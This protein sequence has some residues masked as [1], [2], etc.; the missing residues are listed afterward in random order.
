MLERSWRCLEL[1]QPVSFVLLE[2]SFIKE[3]YVVSRAGTVLAY[4]H[5]G[6]HVYQTNPAVFYL[7]N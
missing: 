7:S 6:A 2:A 4:C 5:F 3:K 1:E